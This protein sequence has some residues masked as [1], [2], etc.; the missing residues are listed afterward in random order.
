MYKN[1]KYNVFIDIELENGIYIFDENSATG[2]T[3]LC[4][5]L[6]EF[7]KMGEPVI[8]YTYGDNNLGI[9]LEEVFKRINPKVLL[10][11]RYDMY[12]GTFNNQILQWSNNTIILI[13][14]K[15]DLEIN[16]DVEWCTIEMTASKI[17]VVQ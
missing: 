16:Y 15:G 5:E 2:K 7:Q 9:N 8:G 13:D 3:R 11:D 17:E 12:N 14:C 1:N 4:K 6:K 10:L